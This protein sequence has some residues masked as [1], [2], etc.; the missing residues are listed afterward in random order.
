MHG[1]TTRRLALAS[2]GL[3]LSRQDA[4]AEPWPTRPLR[5]IVPFEAGSITDVVPRVVLEQLAV[6]LGQ[7]VV[8]VNRPGGAQTLGA[9]A[10]ARSDPDG[11]T[12]LA[13]SAAHAIAPALNDNLSY[14]PVRDFA[15]VSPLGVVPSLL[16][17]PSG[18][19]FNSVHDL[20]AAARA[21]P[22]AISFASA[23]V[24]TATH[25]S[26]MLLLSVAGVQALHVPFRGGGESISAVLSGRVDFFFAPVGV[27]LQHVNEGRLNALA[28]NSRERTSA[29]PSVPTVSELGFAEAENPFWLGMFVPAATRRS[30]VA[31]L[32]EETLKALQTRRVRDR[33]AGLGVDPMLMTPGEFDAYV[34]R[35]VDRSAALVRAIGLRAQ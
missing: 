4:T 6:Q 5:A 18:R 16:V 35:E 7:P 9:A 29:V 2:L 11:Y 14:D 28:V 23:G 21:R 33:L 15:A 1:V 32:H 17:V 13:N 12:L 30:I 20:I 8:I 25:L 3:L 22:D 31:R 34:R 19:G 10:A 24:G 26:A 27:A